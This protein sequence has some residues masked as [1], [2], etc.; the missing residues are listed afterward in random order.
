MSSRIQRLKTKVIKGIERHAGAALQR[1]SH[2]TCIL[3]QVKKPHSMCAVLTEQ[4]PWD[5]GRGLLYLPACKFMKIIP[6]VKILAITG[7]W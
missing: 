2:S 4:E 6:L 3:A 7:S 1:A 5:T